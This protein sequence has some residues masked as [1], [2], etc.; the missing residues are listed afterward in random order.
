MQA[1]AAVGL[2]ARPA[3]PRLT[4]SSQSAPRPPFAVCQEGGAPGSLK[5]LKSFW[6]PVGFTSK[7][8]AEKLERQRLS[9]LKNGRLAML[10]IT[11][12]L[13]ANTIPGSIP[14]PINFP[15]A[16]AFVLPF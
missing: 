9:E 4:P 10:G 2:H 5:G 15:D 8:S 12:V 16:A 1:Q 3:H 7:L 14:L 13:I 6:D 11:S